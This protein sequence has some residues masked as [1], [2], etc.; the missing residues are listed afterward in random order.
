VIH[1]KNNSSLSFYKMK[2]APFPVMDKESS[3]TLAW[4]YIEPQLIDCAILT[5]KQN[6]LDGFGILFALMSPA[7]FQAFTGQ[8]AQPRVH[9]DVFNGAA[10]A[11]AQT[12]LDLKAY[13]VQEAFIDGFKAEF[14]D[15]VFPHLLEHMKVGRSLHTRS[16]EYMFMDLRARLGILTKADVDHINIRLRMPYVFPE[17]VLSF[18]SVKLNYFRDLAGPGALQPLPQSMKIDIIM[19]CFS[20]ELMPC[21]IKFVSDYPVVANQTVEN[22][23]TA[24]VT[25]VNTVLPLTA[26][27]ATLNMNAAAI[28]VSELDAIRLELAEARLAISEMRA[29]SAAVKTPGGQAVPQRRPAI[30]ASDGPHVPFC[31]LHGP[32]HHLSKGCKGKQPGHK[33]HATW[34]NQLASKWRDLWTSQG[35]SVV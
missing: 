10:A 24:I 4:S 11:I 25:F 35:R 28:H 7:A 33:D 32:C 3:D 2:S 6:S 29:A 27:R 34:T 20:D 13:E 26:T 22:L 14:I 19:S 5:G 21:R 31:W 15:S 30:S 23:C 17:N 9:P 18:L 12:S 1:I 16:L 8:A